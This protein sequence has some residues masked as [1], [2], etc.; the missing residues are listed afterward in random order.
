MKLIS[1]LNGSFF[2]E[3]FGLNPV[4]NYGYNKQPASN[5]NRFTESGPT[6]I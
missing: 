5:N 4:I 1:L 6:L 2:N 3:N